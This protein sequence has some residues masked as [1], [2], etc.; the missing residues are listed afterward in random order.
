MSDQYSANY[1]LRRLLGLMRFSPY[2]TIAAAISIFTSIGF[3][4]LLPLLIRGLI[5]TGVA[6][7]NR[8]AIT[9]YALGIAG[10]CLGAVGQA[11]GFVLD[12]EKT[13][14]SNAGIASHFVVFA[15]AD[16]EAGRKGISA[17]LVEAEAPG[18]SIEIVSFAFPKGLPRE[19]DLVFDVRFLRNP[20][21]V[22]ELKS[23]TGLD[24]R[25][26]GYVAGDPDFASFLA[27]MTALITPLLPRMHGRG[28]PLTF[29]A[30]TPGATLVPGPMQVM[31]PPPD[32]PVVIPD[33]VLAP[34]LDVAPDWRFW[35]LWTMPYERLHSHAW[36]DAVI[37]AAGLAFT[38]L[39]FLLVLLI[40]S[41]FEL[42]GI[43]LV[44]QM[45]ETGWFPW[46]LAGAAFGLFGDATPHRHLA[47]SASLPDRRSSDRR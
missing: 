43:K 16:P 25:V 14:I 38:G 47:I 1:L 7:G 12:G 17:F 41:M 15:N 32:S 8:R 26:S 44:M 21:Y 9:E 23:L 3:S 45:F 35:K 27:R 29:H 4:L 33:I 34:L 39:T 36:T 37:G 30:W 20:F 10:A 40:G 28:R 5:N 22:P 18:L 6:S 13:F 11:G 31:E 2:M 19:A 46:M 24:A 42:I